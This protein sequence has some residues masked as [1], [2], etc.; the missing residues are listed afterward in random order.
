M[1]IEIKKKR[2]AI[3]R[4]YWAWI[5]GGTVAAVVLGWLA[6]GSLADTQSVERR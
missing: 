5:G 2:Y 4:K 1:D 6:F 3:P